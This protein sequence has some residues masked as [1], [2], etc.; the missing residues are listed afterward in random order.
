MTSTTLLTVR[1]KVNKLLLEKEFASKQITNEKTALEICKEKIKDALEAQNIFQFNAE[2][3]QTKAHAQISAVVTKSLRIVF[4]PNHSFKIEFRRARGKTEAELV[5]LKNGEEFDPK[6]ECGGGLID[7]AA[8]ALRLSCLMLSRPRLRR[9]IISDEPFKFVNGEE[10]QEK[11][12]NLIQILAE[13]MKVQFL[14]VSDDSW[15]KV[16]HVVEL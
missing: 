13:E 1:N 3:I 11:V 7:V 2:A 14:I 6:E 10:Y 12:G 9:I 15:L 8:F 5:F 16:G 4:G